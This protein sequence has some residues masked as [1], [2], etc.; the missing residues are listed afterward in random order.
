MTMTAGSRSVAVTGHDRAARR[1][2]VVAWPL[3]AFTV[4]EPTAA[5][6]LLGLNAY[7]IVTGLLVGVYTGMVLLATRVLP[8]SHPVDV[9]YHP[10][11][12]HRP[13][14]PGKRAASWPTRMRLRRSIRAV[15][16]TAAR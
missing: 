1:A 8:V 5:L 9:T 2:R 7:A 15:T 13:A 16:T 6:V 4:L 10:S 14:R 11:D 12:C 3:A